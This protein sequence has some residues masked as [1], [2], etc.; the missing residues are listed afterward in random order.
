MIKGYPYVGIKFWLVVDG[1]PM[2]RLVL[3]LSPENS[4]KADCRHEVNFVV[5]GGR[6]SCLYDNTLWRQWRQSWHHDDSL[7]SNFSMD[8]HS[9]ICGGVR[10]SLVL[11]FLGIINEPLYVHT[12]KLQFNLVVNY[13]TVELINDGDLMTPV[14]PTARVGNFT[15]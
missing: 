7:F 13:E 6:G 4:V 2:S 14:L 8:I 5:T 12:Q 15:Q 1:T 10:K 9:L 3:Q 11:T